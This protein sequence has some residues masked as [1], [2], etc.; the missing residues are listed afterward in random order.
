MIFEAE[1]Q[2]VGDV[3]TVRAT[4]N[5]RRKIVEI[6][7]KYVM[8][9]RNWTYTLGH[10]NHPAKI[11]FKSIT[12]NPKADVRW[13]QRMDFEDNLDEFNSLLTKMAAT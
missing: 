9:E 5:K 1:D 6:H 8:V 7:D 12:S 11:W 3:I 4:G 10:G 2:R 13:E